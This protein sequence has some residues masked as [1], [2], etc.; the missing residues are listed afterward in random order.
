MIINNLPDNGKRNR[1]FTGL[2]FAGGL[3]SGVSATSS[4][5]KYR[6]ELSGKFCT[7][8]ASTLAPAWNCLVDSST[9]R[10]Q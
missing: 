9:S 4:R 10:F 2:P 3:G 1:Y 6:S 8:T 5:S 7:S